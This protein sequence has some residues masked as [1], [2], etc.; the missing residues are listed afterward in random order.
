MDDEEFMPERLYC[1]L[2]ETDERST[3][4]L[5]FVLVLVLPHPHASP[6]LAEGRL[7]C[8]PSW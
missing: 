3:R 2:M 4:V 6:R 7:L 5:K 1:C 8:P